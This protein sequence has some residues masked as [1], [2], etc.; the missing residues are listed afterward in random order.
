MRFHFFLTVEVALAGAYLFKEDLA[1]GG[2]PPGQSA[3][4]A[5]VLG[6]LGVILSVL[7]FI[8]GAQD[9]WYYE[10][11][12]QRLNRFKSTH[13]LSQIESWGHEEEGVKFRARSCRRFICFKIPRVGVTAFAAMC[14]LLSIALWII[15]VAAWIIVACFG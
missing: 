6:T 7:W 11:S 9:Y 2:Q 1:T 12:R 8:I 14:P 13:I 10:D 3:V 5:L 4:V 15:P